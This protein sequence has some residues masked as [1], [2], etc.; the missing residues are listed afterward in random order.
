MRNHLE[1][2][3]EELKKAEP[4]EVSSPSADAEPLR[5]EI[6]KLQ[7]KAFQTQAELEKWR[8]TADE[9]QG[10]IQVLEQASMETRAQLEKWK[11]QADEA[12]MSSEKLDDECRALRLEIADAERLREGA[13]AAVT[14]EIV[15]TL[16]QIEHRG[17]IKVDLN[18][19]DV[20][21]LR[22]MEF[23]PRKIS[24][25]PS[26]V[27]VDFKASEPVLDD[28]VQIWQIFPVAMV[29]EGHTKAT[30]GSAEWAQKLA[31]N[32]AAMIMQNLQGKGIK[33]ELMT[34]Q[35]MPGTKGM[36]RPCVNIKLDI[37][38]QVN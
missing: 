27:L 23:V 17:N 10:S 1:T 9:R 15:S 19:G 36:N 13:K 20:E 5:Q 8:R 16:K 2:A 7:E 11:K 29:I 21:I 34:A 30:G 25:E 24:E 26:A 31:Y 6:L 3:F 35:G 38:P 32:R 4:K 14:A 22:A 33:K 37:F 28:I 18:N 12:G